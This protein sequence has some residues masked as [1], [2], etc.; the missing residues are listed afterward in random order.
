MILDDLRRS[1]GRAIK[2]FRWNYR[3]PIEETAAS[4]SSTTRYKTT[5]RSDRVFSFPPRDE[6]GHREREARA[7]LSQRRIRSGSIFSPIVA[8]RV[9]TRKDS[10]TT[11]IGNT[12]KFRTAEKDIRV[13]AWQLGQ[14][15]QLGSD[16]LGKIFSSPGC[17]RLIFWKKR[18]SEFH[19]VAEGKHYPTTRMKMIDSDW[20]TEKRDGKSFVVISCSINI[21]EIKRRTVIPLPS[22]C[23][24]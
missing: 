9:L 22:P 20:Q 16:I 14:Q 5:N 10:T 8:R 18:N 2:S 21:S 4:I 11:I 12:C 17:V 7:D 6:T 1:I 24:T 23:M 13:V 19:R 3:L 15:G